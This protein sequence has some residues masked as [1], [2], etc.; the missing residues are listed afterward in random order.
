[1][2]APPAALGPD[3]ARLWPLDPAC[4]FLNHGS[5]GSVPL[6]VAEIEPILS[7]RCGTCHGDPPLPGLVPFPDHARAAALVERI[8]A[9]IQAGTMPPSGLEPLTVEERALVEAWAEGGAPE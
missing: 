8:V 3:L 5:F 7:A 6:E 9:R 2:H 4:T 1:M